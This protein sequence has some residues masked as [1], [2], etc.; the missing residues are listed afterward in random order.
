MGVGSILFSLALT[1]L[2]GLYL[3][4]PFL[5]RDNLAGR[6]ATPQQQLLEQKEAVLTQILSLDFD[7]DTGKVPVEV[8]E[9]QRVEMV[10]EAA[11]LLERLDNA[12]PNTAVDTQ[13]EAAIAELRGVSISSVSVA[14]GENGDGRFC[15][16]CGQ[17]LDPGD[18]FC[19][20]CG[21]KTA[22]PA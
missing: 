10:A 13:I 1:L 7:F 20:H 8:Y 2:V 16:Q 5:K 14:A 6:H 21:N 11:V 18:K 22:V 19:A 4:R 15:S 3:A 12:P 9:L 17:P